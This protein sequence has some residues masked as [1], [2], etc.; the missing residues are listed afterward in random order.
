[1]GLFNAFVIGD[2]YS[3]KSTCQSQSLCSVVDSD[4]FEQKALAINKFILSNLT[5]ESNSLHY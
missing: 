3:N 1:M 5:S 4:G 2:V